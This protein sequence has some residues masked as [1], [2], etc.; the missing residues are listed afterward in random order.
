MVN[1]ETGVKALVDAIEREPGRA[2][3][4]WWPWAPLVQLMR[5]LPTPFT[6][7]FA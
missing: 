7:R 6:N 5:F 4:P 2:V 3:V 1:N